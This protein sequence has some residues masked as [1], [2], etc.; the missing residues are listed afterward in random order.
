MSSPEKERVDAYLDTI[1]RLEPD[2]AMIDSD[3]GIA[4]IAISL[5][6]I[7]DA[8]ELRNTIDA[9]RNAPLVAFGQ[10]MFTGVVTPG[11]AGR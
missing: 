5:K 4:S 11:S 2:I 3:A 8:L 1:K 9:S 10:P 7:A 6:R